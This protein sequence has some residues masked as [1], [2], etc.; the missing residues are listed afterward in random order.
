MF[1]RRATRNGYIVEQTTLRRDLA[2]RPGRTLPDR[3]IEGTCPICGYDERPRRPVRQLRQPARPDRPDRTRARKI[4][5]ETPEFVETQ[6]F[7]LDL[8]ALADALGEWLDEREASGHLAA[9]RHQVHPEHP[10]GHPAAGDDPRHRLGHP[11]AARRLARAARPSGSTSGSTRSSATCRRRSSGPGA[12]ATRSAGASGGTT[13]EALSYYFMGKDN[14]IFHSQIWPAE[15]LAYDGEGDARRRAGRR[16]AS[17]TCPPRWSPASS[18]RWRASSSPP[19]AASSSTCATC[20]RA[21]SPTRCATSSARPARRTRTADFTW[22]EFVRRTNDE[23]VAGWGNLVNRTATMIAKNFGEIPA[24]GRARPPA[25][26][27]L[28][29]ARRGGVRARSAT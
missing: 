13:R 15:L 22:A 1:T 19:R 21:T 10:R 3:Y 6:H 7:F 8:P 20:S 25:D 12:P 4:N 2:R 28:L 17:S 27:A 29:D 9:Q 26:E 18:S 16:T 24:A 11:G 23:L 5:G 14:I